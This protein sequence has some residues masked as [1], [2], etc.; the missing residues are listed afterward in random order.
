MDR[1]AELR[2]RQANLWACWRV[3]AISADEMEELG[4][5]IEEIE[6]ILG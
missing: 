4:R 6:A 1:L 5:V 3:G 2:N